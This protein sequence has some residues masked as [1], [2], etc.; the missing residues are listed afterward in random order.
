[1]TRANVPPIRLRA[2]VRNRPHYIAEGGWKW[3]GPARKQI[4]SVGEL[5]GVDFALRGR[6]P[7]LSY[8]RSFGAYAASKAKP[9]VRSVWF[10]PL[11]LRSGQALAQRTRK[12]GAPP[13]LVVQARSKA[14]ANRL[15][16]CG[17]PVRLESCRGR[18]RL[19]SFARLGRARAPVPTRPYLI[20]SSI[21]EIQSGRFSTSR[22][23]GPS[24]APTMPSRSMRSM[25]W[26]ARP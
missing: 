12:N 11:R 1:V 24:A 17:Y 26:A 16:S 20:D 10:P 3:C 18:W 23:L 15:S 25:R 22:G 7:D 21:S 13:A 9:I 8:A 14:S 2:R 19:P 6:R 4:W 5:N